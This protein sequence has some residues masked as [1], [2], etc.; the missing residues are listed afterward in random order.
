MGE[1]L[2]YTQ[3]VGGSNPSPPMASEPR[4]RHFRLNQLVYTDAVSDSLTLLAAPVVS[5]EQSEGEPV[6]ALEEREEP[7]T[8]IEVDHVAESI[9]EPFTRSD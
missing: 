8:V 4:F 1:H 9:I 6:E 3:G 2:L 7:L 5:I